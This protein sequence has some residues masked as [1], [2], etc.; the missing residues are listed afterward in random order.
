M[1]LWLVRAGAHCETED[2][3]LEMGIAVIE[4]DM[5]A[6]YDRLSDEIKAELPMK[7]IWNLV[8]EE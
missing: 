2:L 4:W 8:M 1:M 3:A 5:I 7:R 6:Y